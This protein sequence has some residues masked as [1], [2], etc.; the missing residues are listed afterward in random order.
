MSSFYDASSNGTQFLVSLL[1]QGE[2]SVIC[3]V[4]S[5]SGVVAGVRGTWCAAWD[6]VCALPLFHCV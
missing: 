3:E 5:S 6:V 1:S 4:M 2:G